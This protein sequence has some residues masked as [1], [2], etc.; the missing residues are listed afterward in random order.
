MLLPPVARALPLASWVCFCF[1]F[2]APTDWGDGWER[3]SPAVHM[4]T[5]DRMLGEARSVVSGSSLT[6]PWE[7][8]IF[9]EILGPPSFAGDVV[10]SIP[11]PSLLPLPSDADNLEQAQQQA[12]KVTTTLQPCQVFYC[13]FASS[14][15]RSV[16]TPSPSQT[17][18]LLA[19]RFEQASDVGGSCGSG[20]LG[21]GGPVVGDGPGP[22]LGVQGPDRF[23][24]WACRA[25]WRGV[26][27]HTLELHTR[28]RTCTP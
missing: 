23:R 13:G 1:S 5:L 11:K 12:A 18:S 20:V 28:G 8:G 26:F 22:P 7:T 16:V 2:A 3:P 27:G 25:H 15:T 19:Q 10:P 24:S 6:L 4:S 9:R 17:F 21:S 14:L